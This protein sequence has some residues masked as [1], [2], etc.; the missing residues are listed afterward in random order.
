MPFT[1]LS[2]NTRLS[3][4][5][6]RPW[7]SDPICV[8]VMCSADSEH[9]LVS[10]EHNSLTPCGI[11]HYWSMTSIRHNPQVFIWTLNFKE[12]KG[13][14][15]KIPVTLSGKFEF[16]IVF[17]LK[18]K[19]YDSVSL[20][21]KVLQQLAHMLLYSENGDFLKKSFSLNNSIPFVYS[22]T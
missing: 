4:C 14:F 17:T 10:L 21:I 5:F 9:T 2:T 6:P 13:I 7:V 11:L 3:S 20:S 19:Q 1:K 15:Y 8:S 12:Q 18:S 16:L 22:N